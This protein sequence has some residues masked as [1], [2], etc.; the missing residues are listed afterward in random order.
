LHL[1]G[2]LC[3]CIW[4][5]ARKSSLIL[6]F[7]SNWVSSELH[8]LAALPEGK[9]SQYPPNRRLRVPQGW[10]VRFGETKPLSTV[11]NQTTIHAC[12]CTLEKTADRYFLTVFN[13]IIFFNYRIT[14]R[15]KTSIKDD[16]WL[17]TMSFFTSFL[18]HTHFLITKAKF[19]VCSE[20]HTKH[21]D[22][23]CS[24]CGILNVKPC[25]T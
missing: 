20:I 19:P 15:L 3:Y 16:L 7:G 18:L 21:T 23:M 1:V 6:N 5:T 22:S 25:C 8:A 17:W 11:E 13:D 2:C 14:V 10:S 4:S 24:Q 12:P 9:F